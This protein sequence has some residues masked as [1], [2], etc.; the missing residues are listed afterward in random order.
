MGNKKKIKSQSS[1][2]KINIFDANINC[3]ISEKILRMDWEQSSSLE[4]KSLK[5][6]NNFKKKINLFF[7]F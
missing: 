7:I 2:K 4:K 5:K 3:N 1:K 6:T